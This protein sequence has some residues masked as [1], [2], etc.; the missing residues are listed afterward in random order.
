[1]LGKSYYLMTL[2]L[3]FAVTVSFSQQRFRRGIL[4]HHSTGGSIYASGTDVYGSAP[5]TTNVPNECRT[6]N[7][8]HS[9]SGA[10]SVFIG[11]SWWPDGD[12]EWVTWDGLMRNNNVITTWSSYPVIIMKS[13]YPSSALSSAGQPS[14]TL[15]LSAKTVYNYKYLWRRIVR[16]MSQHPEHFFVIWTNAPLSSA[17]TNTASAALSNQFCWWAKDTLSRGLDQQFGSFP[18]NVYVFDFYHYLANSSGMLYDNLWS[19]DGSHPNGYATDTIAPKLVREV[20]DAAIQYEQ[21]LNKPATSLT[22]NPVSI[23][24]NASIMSAQLTATATFNDNTTKNVSGQASWSSSDTSIATVS[25]SG[26]VSAKS[27]GSATITATYTGLN[28][29]TAVTVAEAQFQSVDI[30]PPALYVAP[31]ISTQLSTVLHNQYGGV[32]SSST[33][34][35]TWKVIGSGTITQTGFFT[36]DS[37]STGTLITA[38]VTVGSITHCDTITASVSLCAD[39]FEASQ[40]GQHWTIID[41]DNSNASAAQI[42]NGQLQ[43]TAGGTDIYGATNQFYG[44]YRSDITGNF[45]VS[46]QVTSFTAPADYAKAGIVIANNLTNLSQGGYAMIGLRRGSNSL[47][48][49]YDVSGTIGQINEGDYV[50]QGTSTTP[51]F[52]RMS[53]IGN[54]IR[55]YYKT[56][57]PALWTQIGSERTPQLLGTNS[58]IGLFVN[59]N[60][61]S[62]TA[63][64]SFDNF[65]CIKDI[66]TKKSDVYKPRTTGYNILIKKDSFKFFWNDENSAV[67]SLYSISGRK[68]ITANVNSNTSLYISRP[69]S[70]LYLIKINKIAENGPGSVMTTPLFF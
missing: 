62:Q 27:S 29:Q 31:G 51:C 2:V 46:V 16:L 5:H 22:I 58:Q 6:Y 11:E 56:S 36:A 44:V 3:F 28:A 65:E 54:Q 9:L 19:H 15:N 68:V 4:L 53:R 8:T 35:T 48:F 57:L 49:L 37:S 42:V 50:S 23:S 38:C 45:D 21:Q 64:A 59:S 17:E 20:F 7:V 69:S 25:S 1:M 66:T 52:L 41:L 39:G 67:I 13:C 61:G 63:T 32:Y 55:V 10:D 18:N 26:L 43:I 24:L 40:L 60:S 70:G 12:N 33:S 14:D 34:T 47:Q 30:S